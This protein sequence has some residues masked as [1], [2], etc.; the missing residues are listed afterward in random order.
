M[1]SSFLFSEYRRK[2]LALLL[3]NPQQQYHQRE[4]AR[5]TGT[6]SGTLSREL[7]KMVEASVLLKASVGNQMH[8]RANPDCP[9]YPELVSIL[10]K[11]DGLPEAIAQALAPLSERIKIAFVYGSIANGK[12]TS[13]SDVDLMVI[14][15]VSF[16]ELVT[17]LYPLQESLGREISPKQYAEREWFQLL[18]EQGGFVRDVLA[19]PKLFVIGSEAVLNPHKE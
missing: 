9:I 1:L 3:L 8:Y 19:K 6:I 13:D 17:Q 16:S 15:S 5:L 2:V 12:A 4:I 11:T 7:S 10:R 14:G 18:A